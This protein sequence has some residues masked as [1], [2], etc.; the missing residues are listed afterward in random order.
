MPSISIVD[1]ILAPQDKIVLTF[2]GENPFSVC[3][4]IRPLL[5][6]VLQVE[7]KDTYE[8]VFKWDSTVNPRS[9]YNIWTTNKEEDRWTVYAIKIVIQGTEDINTKK[10]S[11]TIELSGWLRTTYEYSNFLQRA[12]WLFYNRVFY[13]KN[14]REYMIR[15]KEYLFKLRDEIMETLKMPKMA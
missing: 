4:I 7:S 12:L 5:Q 14:R 10:G 11:V 9:F 1:D 15:G 13:Y 3:K 2:S 8:R 6:R